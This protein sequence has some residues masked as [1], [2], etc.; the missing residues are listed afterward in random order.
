LPKLA[1]PFR[2]AVMPSSDSAGASPGWVPRGACHGEDPE[3][4]SPSAAVG[5]ALRQISAAKAVCGRCTVRAACLSHALA[6][7]PDGI[8]GGTTQEERHVIRQASSYRFPDRIDPL[9]FLRAAKDRASLAG[10]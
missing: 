2:E 5:P 10:E 3:L 6:L 1:L 7:R 8:W 9:A 4:F